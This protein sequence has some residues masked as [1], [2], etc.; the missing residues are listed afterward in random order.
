MAQQGIVYKVVKHPI[1]TALMFVGGFWLMKKII[2][3]DKGGHKRFKVKADP[4]R[5]VR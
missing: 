3:S 2:F 5:G 1:F 4:R